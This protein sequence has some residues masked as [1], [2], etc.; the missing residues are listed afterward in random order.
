MFGYIS[1][2]P[3]TLSAE[4]KQRSRAFYCGLCHQLKRRCGQ[5][6][7]MTLS[8]DM[9]FLSLLLCA[10]YEPP[11][12]PCTARCALHP[13]RAHPVVE[14]EAAGYAADINIV[15][16]YHKC[17]DDAADEG[18]LRGR[19][20]AAALKGAYRQARERRPR[21]CAEVERCL[22]RLTVLEKQSCFD[23]D[24]L[25]RLSGQ[26]L[27][28]CFLWREDVFSPWLRA[29]GEALGRFVYLMDAYEDYDGDLRRGRFNPLTALHAQADY[30]ERMEEILTLEM[31]KCVQAFERLPILRDAGLLRNVLYSG[32][33]GRYA[34]LQ[35]KRKEAKA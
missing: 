33:W 18:G 26:M 34:Q 21:Q 23:P 9:T 29:M 10:L 16:A 6:G 12:R 14:Q 11:E 2:N 31:A 1:V 15:L 19:V 32:V 24:A 27:G 5:A 3:H 20:G 13:L 17:L 28:A 35:K 7:R 25:A 22:E 8:N 30:E 4:E